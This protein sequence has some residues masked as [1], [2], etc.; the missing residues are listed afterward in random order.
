M[1][2]K[3]RTS[4]VDRIFWPIVLIGCTG[5]IMLTI[6]V[7]D[8]IIAIHF[9]TPLPIQQ[10]IIATPQPL[11][12]QTPTFKQQQTTSTQKES[13]VS[14]DPII[15]C[16]VGS[17]CGGGTKMIR[18]SVCETSG[19]CQIGNQWVFYTSQAQCVM[20]QRSIVKDQQV[21]RE[22]QASEQQKLQEDTAQAKKLITDICLNNAYRKAQE[23]DKGC[24][25]DS[26]C[27][28][29]CTSNMSAEQNQCLEAQKS[30]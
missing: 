7:K 17:E 4:V 23:C 14:D 13:N 11:S 30:Q 20:D 3:K 10:S 28:N 12:T 29:N 22:K 6:L 1:S 19:C 18:R 27:M 8:V 26:V 21:S 24:S 9:P 5:L 2:E 25:G 16:E 15:S